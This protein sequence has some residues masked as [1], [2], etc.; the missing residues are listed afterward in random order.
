[1]NSL[2]LPLLGVYAAIGTFLGFMFVM[3]MRRSKMRVAESLAT[4]RD[5]AA[6]VDRVPQAKLK[7]QSTQHVPHRRPPQLGQD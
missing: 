3:L 4:S 1:M 2:V 6:K 7:G 5:D